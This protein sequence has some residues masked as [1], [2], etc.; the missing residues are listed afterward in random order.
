MKA[1]QHIQS[2]VYMWLAVISSK[3]IHLMFISDNGIFFY[4]RLKSERKSNIPSFLI[5]LFIFF[6][7][8]NSSFSKTSVNLIQI[9]IVLLLKMLWMTYI[10]GSM[11]QDRLKQNKLMIGYFLA[12]NYQLD[13]RDDKKKKILLS[14]YKNLIYYI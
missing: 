12:L 13:L 8:F 4:I 5:P 7:F 11:A 3:Y 10:T 2:H 1:E 14:L 9:F 6:F